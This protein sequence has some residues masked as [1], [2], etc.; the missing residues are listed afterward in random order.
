MISKNTNS[1]F[2]K[3]EQ[4]FR[5]FIKG[6][7]KRYED[8]GIISYTQFLSEREL[9]VSLSVIKGKCDF[10]VWGGRNNALRTMLSIGAASN[11]DFPISCLKI[12]NSEK[13]EAFNHRH[14]LGSLMSM[15]IERDVIGDIIVENE[16][17]AYFFCVSNMA[18]FILE[19][20]TQIS[21]SPVFIKVAEATEN[22]NFEQRFSETVVSVSSARLDCFVSSIIG[23]SRGKAKEMISSELVYLNSF[24]QKNPDKNIE[25]NDIL[26][27]RGYGRF[28]VDDFLR[29]SRKGKM[30]YKIRKFV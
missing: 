10:S 15:G 20:L 29:Q 5:S 4:Y 1:G 6:L 7:I 23:V 19:N 16:H 25:K 17:S 14:I 13:S 27:I 28:I 2:E 8:R 18:G 24:Q 11:E 12:S 22:L 26:S 30:Q 3:E 21:R 9:S